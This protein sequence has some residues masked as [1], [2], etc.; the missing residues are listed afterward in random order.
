MKQ[1][2]FPYNIFDRGATLKTVGK[3]SRLNGFSVPRR[4]HIEL[5]PY[6][7]TFYGS[8]AAEAVFILPLLYGRTK[9]QPTSKNAHKNVRFLFSYNVV[10]EI[11]FKRTSPEKPSEG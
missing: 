6:K 3:P 4:K 1:F 2:V 10:R 7:F 9:L 11:R 5:E 8:A